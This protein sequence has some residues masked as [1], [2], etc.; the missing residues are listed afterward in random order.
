MLFSTKDD[1]IRNLNHWDAETFG[2]ALDRIVETDENKS[3]IELTRL[4]V[5]TQR[6]TDKP[7]N[8]NASESLKKNEFE[9]MGVCYVS[10]FNKLEN[11][12]GVWSPVDIIHEV[13]KNNI[14]RRKFYE[15][16]AKQYN[17][18]FEDVTSMMCGRAL[19][20]LPSYIREHQL[21]NALI[22]AFPHANF[23]HSEELDKKLHCDIMMEINGKRYYFWSFLSSNQSIGQFIDKFRNNR[24]GTIPDGY[25]V[26][27]PFDRDKEKSA[28]YKGW[29]F[30]SRNYIN[31]IK[32][33]IYQREPYEYYSTCFSDDIKIKPLIEKVGFYRRPVVI[34]KSK[35]DQAE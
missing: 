9:R 17:T 31:E 21:E 4:V 12:E 8:G 29:C 18:T 23:Y 30:Y 28:S 1:M 6:L 5:N 25:H 22:N 26:L 34:Y 24:S 7:M 3:S 33:A 15:K 11:A 35:P 27:C 16:K 14:G 20:A 32:T 19:R 10:F 13:C 2:S